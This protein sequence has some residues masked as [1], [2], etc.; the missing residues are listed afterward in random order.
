MNDD[1]YMNTSR[2]EEVRTRTDCMA[3]MDGMELFLMILL[4]GLSPR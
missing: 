4:T 3:Y 1:K 2:G